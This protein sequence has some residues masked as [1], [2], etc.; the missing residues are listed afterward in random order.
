MENLVLAIAIIIMLIGFAGTILPIIPGV[1]LVFIAIL[2]YA[3][4]G[5]FQDIQYPYLIF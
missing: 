1:A 5:D 2:G 4:Y 3:W